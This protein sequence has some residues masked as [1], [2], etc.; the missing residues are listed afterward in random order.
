MQANFK[1]SVTII[2]VSFKDEVLMGQLTRSDVYKRQ[3]QEIEEKKNLT[4]NFIRGMEFVRNV[5]S[6]N[7]DISEI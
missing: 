3:E 4:E 2:N 5:K 1:Q 7:D 6:S